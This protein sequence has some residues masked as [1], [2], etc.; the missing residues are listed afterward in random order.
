MEKTKENLQKA[1]A[2]E[3][4]ARN[5]YMYFAKVAKNEGF[6]YIAKIFEET[7]K[8]EEQH[9]KEELKLLKGISSTKDNLKA[10]ID[11]E[12]H[13]VVSMYPE[14][15]KTAKEDGFVEAEE[16]FNQIA[17][18]E[19]KHEDRFRKL[20]NLV[21]SGKVFI[22][23]NPIDWKCS[24]CGFVENSNEAPKIC[25]CCKHLQKNFEPVCSCE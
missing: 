21:E 19:K 1:F 10:S 7:A 22:R 5:K 17:L 12:H 11:G 8:N 25:P 15:A 6:N 16:L 13:E 3:S 18:A 9:A 20:L 2:G 4:Q 23:E 24:K 14:F